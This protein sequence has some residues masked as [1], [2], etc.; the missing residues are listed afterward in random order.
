M[1]L[2]VGGLDFTVTE[3]GLR[4]RIEKCG[5]TVLSCSEPIRPETG[6]PYCFVN[7]PKEQGPK[8]IQIL[9]GRMFFGRK[10][11]VREAGSKK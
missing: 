9:N 6:W 7:V 4:E 5:V 2:W 3:P 10:I 11:T 8:A 1:R